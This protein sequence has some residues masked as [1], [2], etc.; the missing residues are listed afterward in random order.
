MT[1]NLRV[2][3]RGFLLH[4]H[5]KLCRVREDGRLEFLKKGRRDVPNGTAV[6]SLQDVAEAVKMH[7]QSDKKSDNLK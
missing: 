6:I 7:L 5:D 4:G 3:E 1:D 2:D